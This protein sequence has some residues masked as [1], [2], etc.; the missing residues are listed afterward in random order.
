MLIMANKWTNKLL[1]YSLGSFLGYQGLKIIGR[2]VFRDISTDAIKT[3]MTDLYD[4]NIW[5]FVSATT[6][7]SPQVVV[8]TNLRAQEGKAIKRPLGSPKKMPSLDVQYWPIAYYAH[9]FGNTGGYKSCYR[10]KMQ[11]A[12]DH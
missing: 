6:K 12:I 10:Q 4:E 7:F 1:L 5:E 2:K 11:K 3:I 8:E 9:P